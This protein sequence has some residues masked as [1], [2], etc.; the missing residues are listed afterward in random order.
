VAALIEESWIFRLILG[1]R[2]LR[3]GAAVRRRQ[4]APE[5]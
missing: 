4:A 5:R 2:K 1:G 3:V